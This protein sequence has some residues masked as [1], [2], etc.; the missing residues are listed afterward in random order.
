ML[1]FRNGRNTHTMKRNM[2]R[3]TAVWLCMAALTILA[4]DK[5]PKGDEAKIAEKDE[6]VAATGITYAVDTA[7]SWVKFTGYGVGKNHPG[8]FR[9]NYGAVAVANDSLSGG[10]FV[11]SIKSMKMEQKGK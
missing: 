6:V 7:H 2:T 8:R 11:I 3:R 1:F 9:L 5:Q 10:S 4:C